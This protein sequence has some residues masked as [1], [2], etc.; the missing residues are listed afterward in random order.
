MLSHK[1]KREVFIFGK[2]VVGGGGGVNRRQV[3][4][5]RMCLSH[6]LSGALSDVLNECKGAV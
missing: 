4:R 1:T 2:A 5:G 3:D 6:T